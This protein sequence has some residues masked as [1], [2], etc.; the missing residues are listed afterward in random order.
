MSDLEF[1]SDNGGAEEADDEEN[2]SNDD[3]DDAASSK[4]E[5][6]A[7]RIA[8]LEAAVLALGVR[9][10]LEF[11]DTEGHP[12]RGNQW[13]VHSKTDD[14]KDAFKEALK[15]PVPKLDAENGKAFML[16]AA[17]ELDKAGL[18]RQSSLTG[19]ELRGWTESQGS[20]GFAMRPASNYDQKAG[21]W[22]VDP[23]RFN[24]HI[25]VD[26]KVAGLK[27]TTSYEKGYED[28]IN[29]LQTPNDPQSVRDRIQSV[30]EDKLGMKVTEV[31]QSGH[32]MMWDNDV[33]YEITMKTPKGTDVPA[34]ASAER[35]AMERNARRRGY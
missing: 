26:G 12:F 6:L 5:E 17:A 2:N 33:D 14:R 25:V 19:G 20:I 10:T 1:A 29:E 35:V 31:R 30:F 13:Q 22:T 34:L 7:A 3:A 18:S 4:D 32:Q 8:D 15:G 11:G 28:D 23:T 21:K 24:A 27:Y 16:R 9:E